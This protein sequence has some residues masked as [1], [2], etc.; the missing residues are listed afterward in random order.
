MMQPLTRRQTLI[1]AASGL[2]GAV[3]P[4]QAHAQE[5][6]S[7]LPLDAHGWS[8]A[9]TVGAPARYWTT[10]RLSCARF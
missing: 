5:I 7:D 4:Q 6:L 9:P 3:L 2:A 10:P 8:A 1:A